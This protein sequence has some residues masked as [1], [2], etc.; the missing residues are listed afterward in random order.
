M[1]T[2]AFA[3]EVERVRRVY[4]AYDAEGRH[5]TLWSPF[6]EVEAAY[7]SRQT[8]AMAAL[9]RDARVVSLEGV[10]ILDIGCGRGRHLRRFLDMG[11]SPGDLHGIDV[12]EPSL[13]VARSLSPHIAFTLFNG[14]EIPFPDSSFDLV[15]QFV[16]FSSISLLELRRHIAAEMLRVLRPRGY[17]FW[18]DTLQL[19]DRNAGGEALDAASLFPTLDRKQLKIGRQPTL[20][21]CVRVPPRVR[22]FVRGA[23]DRL[24]LVN[25]PPTH[26]AALLGPKP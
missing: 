11:A 5:Q 9:M 16:V 7:R 3:R 23:L 12:H 21:E 14:W 18:W 10:R 20:G 6:D 24:P 19:A 1:T 13:E 8:F 15:T 26:A 25:Y 22:P 4:D 2:D 17:V